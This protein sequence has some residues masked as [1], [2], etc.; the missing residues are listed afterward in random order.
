MLNCVK[1]VD[2]QQFKFLAILLLLEFLNY[3]L[4]TTFFNGLSTI[5][6]VVIMVALFVY[7][8]LRLDKKTLSYES[9]FILLILL[10][11]VILSS[12]PVACAMRASSFV[13]QIILIYEL[14]YRGLRENSK[15]PEMLS[16]LV[17]NIMMLSLIIS[18][19]NMLLMSVGK[20]FDIFELGEMIIGNYVSGRFNGVFNTP[21]FCIE[22]SIITLILCL[23]HEGNH[24]T[25]IR[26]LGFLTSL[27]TF[28]LCRARAGLVAIIAFA[29]VYLF[30]CLTNYNR[31]DGVGN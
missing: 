28:I 19:G 16:R 3:V 22:I 15:A 2:K 30:F 6:D 1:K 14:P 10:V 21:A 8:F 11:K 13:V 20:L 26:G 7:E 5:C 17:H 31:I 29:I 9:I 18:I 24:K 25:L 27:L 4:T 23:M 12:D